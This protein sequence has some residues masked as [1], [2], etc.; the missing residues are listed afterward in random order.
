MWNDNPKPDLVYKK[1]KA[2]PVIETV[3]AVIFDVLVPGIFE[4][5]LKQAP[6]DC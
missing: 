3:I 1:L 5:P 4:G 6:V 2:G